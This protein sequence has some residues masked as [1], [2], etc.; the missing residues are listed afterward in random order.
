ME[1]KD[2]EAYKRAEKI[3]EEKIGFYIHIVTFIVV[4]IVLI[5]INVVTSPEYF[6][7]IWP[8]LGWGIGLVFHGLNVFVVYKGSSITEKMIKKEMDKESSRRNEY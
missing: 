2:N 3:V 1:N 4:N 6:W 5:V 7:F 8:L